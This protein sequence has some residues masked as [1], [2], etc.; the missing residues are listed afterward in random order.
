MIDGF[1]HRTIRTM[2]GDVPDADI[3]H[4]AY[5]PIESRG[6][7]SMESLTPQPRVDG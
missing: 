7:D 6:R 5:T 2:R 3:R 4:T 1:V